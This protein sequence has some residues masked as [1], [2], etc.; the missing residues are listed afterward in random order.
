[1]DVDDQDIDEILTSIIN[2]Q[3]FALPMHS[4][5]RASKHT[6]DIGLRLSSTNMREESPGHSLVE[7]DD[8]DLGIE[9]DELLNDIRL[10]FTRKARYAQLLKV[11]T[12]AKAL[13]EAIH[14]TG[15]QVCVCSI[16]GVR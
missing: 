5:S 4:T 12:L 6:N 8:I 15:A 16:G 7:V 14:E 9:E 10:L 3:D 1:M 11:R 13:E 2:Y